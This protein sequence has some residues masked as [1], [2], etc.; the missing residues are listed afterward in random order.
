MRPKVKLSPAEMVSLRLRGHTLE[1]I[2]QKAGISQTR[3]Q[4]ITHLAA[5]NAVWPERK[6]AVRK[7]FIGAKLDADVKAALKRHIKNTGESISSFISEA[8][9]ERLKTLG[10]TID[11]E[12]VDRGEPL[13]F[14]G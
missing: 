12:P 10:V 14:E 3:V 2:G 5:P 11:H 4:Q 1:E 8:V 6:R 13:P 7:E 9:E